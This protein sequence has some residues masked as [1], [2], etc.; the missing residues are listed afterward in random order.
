MPHPLVCFRLALRFAFF[1]SASAV[2]SEWNTL[3]SLVPLTISSSAQGTPLP[4]SF[5]PSPSEEFS[6]LDV[7]VVPCG[8]PYANTQRTTALEAP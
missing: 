4:G 8:H 2:P 6:V 5:F 1:P 3:P 7:S